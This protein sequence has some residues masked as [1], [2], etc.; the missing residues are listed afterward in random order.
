M[1]VCDPTGTLNPGEVYI[2]HG[3]GKL[4]STNK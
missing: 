1:G 2:L 4:T 3:K